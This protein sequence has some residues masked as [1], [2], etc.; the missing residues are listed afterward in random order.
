MAVA[1][2]AWVTRGALLPR[3]PGKEVV[4]GVGEGHNDERGAD[5]GCAVAE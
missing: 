4:G 2:S 3:R 1:L 5:N